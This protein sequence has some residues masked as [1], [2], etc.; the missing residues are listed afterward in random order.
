MDGTAL[1]VTFNETLDTNSLPAGSQFTL[2]GG[3]E[4]TGT[5]SVSGATASVTL[6]NALTGGST[7]TVSYT[8]PTSN[9]L[10]DAA[11]NDVLSFSNQP[12]IN[13]IGVLVSN[14]GQASDGGTLTTGWTGTVRWD[15]AVTFTTGSNLTG[16]TLSAVDVKLGSG[17]HAASTRVS[18]YT[19]VTP[20]LKPPEPASSLHLLTNP[21]SLTASATNTFTAAAGATLDADTTYAVVFEVPSGLDSTELDRTDSH[22]EDSWT[23]SGWS[24]ADHRFTRTDGGNWA[25]GATT[26]P[27]KP[28]IAIRGTAKP[29]PPLLVSNTG[30]TDSDTVS[31]GLNFDRHVGLA[32]TTGGNTAGYT[33]SLV[34]ARLGSKAHA[35]TQVSIYTTSNGLPDSSLHVLNNPSSL[36]ASAINTFLADAGA[37]LAANTTYA[38]VFNID[39]DTLLVTHDTILRLT[40]SA[41]EDAGA[42]SGW[43]IADESYLRDFVG[44]NANLG[45]REMST[46]LKPFIAIRATAKPLVIT[47]PPPRPPEP[48]RGPSAP[49]APRNL[50]AVGGYGEVVL[51]WK[52][53]VSDG[54]AAIT[55]YEYR[56]N[57]RR[58]WISIG[59]TQTTHTVTSLDSGAAYVFDVRAVNSAGKSGA[60]NRA[61]ATPKAPEVLEFTHFV[62]GDGATSDLVLVN[63]GSR[64]VRPALYFYDT[65][66]SPIGAESVVDIAGDLKVAEDGA[67]TVRTGMEPLGELTVSTHGREALVTGSVKVVSEGLLGGMLRFRLPHVGEA[68]VKASTPVGDAIFPVRRRQGGINTGVAIHNLESRE[69]QVDCDLL[70]E[71]VLLD[72]VSIALAANGQISWSI[73]QAFT[74]ADTTDFAGSVRC[75]AVGG[76]RFSAIALE[77]NSGTRVFTTLP[78]MEVPR[79]S[80]FATGAT[81][82]NFAHFAN[83]G[84]IISELVLVNL[85]TRP[86]RPQLSPFHPAI[87]PTRPMIY[88]YDP[89]G[90]PI[91]PETVVDIVGDLEITEDGALTVRN[92]MVP[93]G[94]L[95]VSTHG[96]EALVTGSVK[97]VSEGPIG[98]MLRYDLPHV[99]QAVVGG[100]RGHQRRHLPGAAP[101]GRHQHRGCDSQPGIERGGGGL[102]TAARG[103]PA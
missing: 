51:R 57:R 7:V 36:T 17:S 53:P 27:E 70:R 34:Q 79:A 37:T 47:R 18:I 71:G 66:G 97:V 64:P 73:D 62:N 9:P 31:V 6:N 103:R 87:P 58:P 63:V 86:S 94:E 56:I 33:L 24:I 102:R 30:Q 54:G 52:A 23:A 95:T 61:E 60:S 44:S 59:S 82:L 68:V 13:T 55:D 65:E 10:Q 77:M 15:R 1:T 8:Q 4:G 50:A 91:A 39:L 25:K 38:V 3:Q 84:S 75:D 45:W 99:G 81:T 28:M 85:E 80:S 12:V 93:L 69:A 90:H 96:R 78:V 46:K 98:G 88:F 29:V 74:A 11:G 32:F 92:E 48:P 40:T 21:S 19:T 2:S 76:A 100:Q 83:G 35:N 72:A 26:T 20:H 89:E 14:I 67:L 22:A 49:S 42:A 43:S 5:V 101:A 16:Y 41:S